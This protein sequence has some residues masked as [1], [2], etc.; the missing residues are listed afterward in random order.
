MDEREEIVIMAGKSVVITGDAFDGMPAA[1]LANL[2]REQG[3]DA[4]CNA[5]QHPVE[6]MMDLVP[7]PDITIVAGWK[8]TNGARRHQYYLVLA[9]CAGRQFREYSGTDEDTSMPATV[10]SDVCGM[11][12]NYATVSEAVALHASSTL[13][14]PRKQQS[15]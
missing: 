9:H 13:D 6:A 8:A 7:Q 1:G 3:L 10:C 5:S 15:G 4:R 11:L 2:L 14:G 12:N